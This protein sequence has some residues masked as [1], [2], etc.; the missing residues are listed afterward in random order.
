M[1]KGATEIVVVLDR[2]GSMQSTKTD[3]EGGL[4]AFVEKQRELPGECVLTLYRFDDTIERVFEEKPLVRVEPYDLQLV[5]RG[6]TALLD[7]MDRAIDEVGSRLARRADYDRPE[8]IYFVTITDGYENASRKASPASVFDK[9][10]HQRD[11]YGW[12]F[13]FIGA[14]QDAIATAS[15]L[16]IGAQY[17]LTYRDSSMGTKSA[18][19]SMSDGILRSRQ[20]GGQAVCF[21]AQERTEA[22]ASDDDIK[23]LKTTFGTS[24][25]TTPRK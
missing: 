11:K 17:S 15:K 7:A 20:L 12:Q 19:N 22:M 23:A 6:S 8:F 14:N 13:V 25:V 24:S 16:G 1:K 21:T 4:K 9:V 10:T 5:P 3:A 18:Y 2:S